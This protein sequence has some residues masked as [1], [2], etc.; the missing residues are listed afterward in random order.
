MM[1]QRELESTIGGKF[2]DLSLSDTLYQLIKLDQGKKAAKL[3]GDFKVPD[4]RYW[5]IKVRALGEIHNW[6]A[7]DKFAK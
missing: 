1:I 5:W 7:L 2:I 4:K 6:A 3:K